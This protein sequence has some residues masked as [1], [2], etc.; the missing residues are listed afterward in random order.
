MPSYKKDPRVEF[1]VACDLIKER[2]VKAAEDYGIPGI[3]TDYRK[4]IDDYGL[5]AVSIGTSNDAHGPVSIYAAQKGINIFCEK[6]MAMTLDEAKTMY[7]TVQAAGIVHMVDFSKRFMATSRYI[8]ELIDGGTLGRFYSVAI[9]YYQGYR[10]NPD[11]P[12][13]WRV[14]KQRAGS[15]VLGDLGSHAIDLVRF[16]AGE[17]DIVKG[18]IKTLVD[19]RPGEDGLGVVKVDCDDVAWVAGDTVGG[20]PYS[21]RTTWNAAGYSDELR[22]ELYF[23]KGTVLWRF[24]RYDAI[25]IQKSASGWGSGE[26][27]DIKVSPDYAVDPFKRFI[28]HCISGEPVGEP[29]FYDGLMV[30]KVLDNVLRQ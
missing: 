28:N 25:S 7:D 13:S 3:E 24:H 27:E 11:L 4:V 12:V 5:D 26:L 17:P 14:Q 30:Q 15:G 20:V 8:K 18:Y 29:T 19:N 6:P 16:W 9:D 2:A 23:E 1:V 21:I 10:S 22:A